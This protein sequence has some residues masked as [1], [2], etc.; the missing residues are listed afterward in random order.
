VR[1]DSDCRARH[2]CQHSSGLILVPAQS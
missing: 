1:Q 2:G